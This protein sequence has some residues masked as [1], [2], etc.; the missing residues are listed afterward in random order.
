MSA[1]GLEPRRD[2]RVA[3]EFEDGQYV[4]LARA[5]F[6]LPTTSPTASMSSCI[7]EIAVSFAP[8]PTRGGGRG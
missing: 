5:H 6:R 4:N 7:R 3:A 2:A 8:A 1:P